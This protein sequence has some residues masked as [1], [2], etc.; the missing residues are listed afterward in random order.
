M[1]TRGATTRLRLS[2]NSDPIGFTIRRLAAERVLANDFRSHMHVNV[3]ASSEGR[4]GQPV[5]VCQ[6][7]ATDTLSLR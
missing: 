6:L 7:E 5:R 3:R 1:H 4:E 2:Q